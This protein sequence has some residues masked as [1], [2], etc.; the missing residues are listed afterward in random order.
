MSASTR[1]DRILYT[2]TLTLPAGA[3]WWSCVWGTVSVTNLSASVVGIGTSFTTTNYVGQF[4]SFAN[5]PGVSYTIKSIASNTALTLTAVFTGA[6]NAASAMGLPGNP[7]FSVDGEVR[8][9]GAVFSNVAPAATFRV[10]MSQDDVN[11][12]TLRPLVLDA[13]ST[14]NY[15][16]DINLVGQNFARLVMTDAGAGSTV[17]IVLYTTDFGGDGPDVIGGVTPSP[18]P[19]VLVPLGFQQIATDSATLQSLTVPAG[20]T[21]ALIQIEGVKARWRDD[22]VAPTATIGFPIL[23]NGT[24]PWLYQGGAAGLAAFQIIGTS[25]VAGSTTVNVSYYR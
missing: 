20:A 10:E 14:N 19:L 3:T 5:Q 7:P 9:K 6:T 11:W 17:R 18:K 1:G 16:F 22:G 25:A 8:I 2:G 12:N 23:P 15:S 4:V 21:Q 24:V 13:G